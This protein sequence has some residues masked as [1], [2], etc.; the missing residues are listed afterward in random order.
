VTRSCKKYG[1]FY[2]GSIGGLVA[3]LARESILKMETLGMERIGVSNAMLAPALP[4][5]TGEEEKGVH[6]FVLQGLGRDFGTIDGR[7]MSSLV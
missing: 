6:A 4:E 7:H 1:G 3:I 5:A 2:L